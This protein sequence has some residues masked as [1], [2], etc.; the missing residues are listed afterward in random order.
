[1][2]DKTEFPSHPFWDFALPL[3]ETKGVGEAVIAM[4]DRHGVNV[5]VLLLSC[6]VGATGRGRLG[7]EGVRKA[8]VAA[9][10]WNREVVQQLRAVRRVMR[11]GIP[12][13]DKAV[14]DGLRR[15]I[16]EVEIDCERAE[17]VMLGQALDRAAKEGL[18]AEARAE[19][20]AANLRDYFKALGKNPDTDDL[21][22]MESLITAAVPD[23]ARSKGEAI[24]KALIQ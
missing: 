16:L 9:D 15:R 6:W 4:Q 18:P 13:I 17:I 21:A 11:P 8:I 3:H 12:P 23:I 19:D 1:M 24:A 5:N 10:K 7:D 14:S 22:Y 20:V 2:A